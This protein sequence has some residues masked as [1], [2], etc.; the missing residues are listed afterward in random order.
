MQCSVRYFKI[1]FLYLFFSVLYLGLSTGCNNSLFS[2]PENKELKIL[3]Q[4]MEKQIYGN[5]SYA[6]IEIGIH[7]K[8]VKRSMLLDSWEDRKA[9]KFFMRVLSPRRDRGVT[10]LKWGN[11]LWQY[12]PRL[13]K[14]IKVEGSLMQDSWMGSDFSNDDLVR[15]S[16]LS[17][18]YTAK[19]LPAKNNTYYKLQLIPKA[20]A[21]VVWNKVV[22]DIR[23]ADWM[24]LLQEFYDHRGRMVRRLVFSKFKRMDGQLMPT[25]YRISSN[26]NGK[27]SS[28]T[29]LK[30]LKVQFNRPIPTRIFSRA[31]LRR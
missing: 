20:G 8:R 28:Y 1:S 27:E 22:L 7:K 12:T 2:Q 26:Q 19:L 3:L 10:F 25:Q 23:K 14:E 6:R 11:N 17:E 15:A 30:Y 13:G 16:T 9:D 5:T 21:P 4:R 29:T 24:P 31:N 18:D